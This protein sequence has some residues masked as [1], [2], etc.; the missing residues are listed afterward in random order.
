MM[1]NISTV[2]K[3][4][5]EAEVVTHLW[6]LN[7]ESYAEHKALNKFYDDLQKLTD[8]LLETC[9]GK[10]E[11]ILSLESIT[12][13]VNSSPIEYLKN[14]GSFI[15]VHITMTSSDLEIQDHFLTIR[16]LINSTLYML[17]R[18]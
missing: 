9:I 12:L 7:T 11:E 18:K 16:N 10:Y 6:H 14:L 13:P 17:R 2:F 1:I 3:K 5:K 15:D 4:L 8:K